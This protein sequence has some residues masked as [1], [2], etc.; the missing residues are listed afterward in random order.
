[1]DERR[2]QWKPWPLGRPLAALITEPKIR[3]HKLSRR[4]LSGRRL[5][6]SAIVGAL[7]A[8]LTLVSQAAFLWRTA[9]RVQTEAD[10]NE[11]VLKKLESLESRLPSID[12]SYDTTE[13]DRRIYQRICK[14]IENPATQEFKVLTIVRDPALG[15]ISETQRDAI[16]EYHRSLEVALQGRRG[17]VYERLVV[18]RTPLRS[19]RTARD[20]LAD[21]VAGRPE[22]VDHYRRVCG[23]LTCRGSHALPTPQR[24]AGRQLR[25]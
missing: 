8:A 1:V 12:W 17:F 25:R 19:R 15:D 2:D 10:R 14:V 16:R 9:G 24:P 21:L 20:L 23:S 22:Y 13:H 3:D 4:T 11:T 18:L 5:L 7:L 6:G